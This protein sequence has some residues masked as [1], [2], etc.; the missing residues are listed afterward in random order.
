MQV[1]PKEPKGPG[2]FEEKEAEKM[3]RASS[4]T[5]RHGETD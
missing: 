2:Q 4:R 3:D 5:L 1:V